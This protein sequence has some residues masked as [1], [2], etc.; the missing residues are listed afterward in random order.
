M[1]EKVNR[2]DVIVAALL[3]VFVYFS[4][5]LLMP[6]KYLVSCGGSPWMSV[7]LNPLSEQGNDVASPHNHPT[8]IMPPPTCLNVY[9]TI[10][11]FP[12][13]YNLRLVLM[14][15]V[16][17]GYYAFRNRPER[18]GLVEAMALLACLYITFYTL[19]YLLLPLTLRFLYGLPGGSG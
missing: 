4:I 15:L 19:V 12:Q 1:F 9:K 5:G 14:L 16:G 7:V 18:G 3:M 17:P 13:Y 10:E 11:P 6:E 2:V 8:H